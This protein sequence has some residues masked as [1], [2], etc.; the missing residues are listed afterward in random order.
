MTCGP[1]TIKA[2]RGAI[3]ASHAAV[4]SALG[5]MGR[6]GVVA[7]QKR[8]SGAR[9]REAQWSATYTSRPATYRR[10]VVGVSAARK[11]A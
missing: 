10:G 4:D 7:A 6:L 5:R 11:A 9:Y 1:M 2:L 3:G 8:C